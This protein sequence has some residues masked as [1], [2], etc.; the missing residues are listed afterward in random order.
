MLA[1]LIEV[2]ILVVSYKKMMKVLHKGV[3]GI[4]YKIDFS[5]VTGLQQKKSLARQPVLHLQ[6][7]ETKCHKNSLTGSAL[8]DTK[9][10]L[11][12]KVFCTDLPKRV[13]PRCYIDYKID[14]EDTQPVNHN[15][16]SLTSEQLKKQICQICYLEKQDLIHLSTSLWGAPVLFVKKKDGI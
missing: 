13:G 6:N 15:V 10:G 5:E 9:L 4:L 16:Y 2:H 3:A 8:F 11:L 12:K 14:T 7:L 1:I